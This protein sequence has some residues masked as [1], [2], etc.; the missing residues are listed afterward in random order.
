M[1]NYIA[2]AI[3]TESID[4]FKVD[5]PRLLHAAL[6]IQT[7]ITELMM[8]TDGVNFK[9]E[10]GDILWYVAVFCDRFQV[11]FED[12][13]PLADM[14][15]VE[16]DPFKAA[17][18]FAGE[19]ID[20]MKRM[21]FYGQE[22]SESYLGICVA[23]VVACVEVFAADLNLTMDEIKEA[24]I[25]KLRRR[26]GEKFSEAAA[27]NRDLAAEEEALVSGSQG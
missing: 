21:C 26:F 14:E 16:D 3:K 12:L 11:R 22:M 13:T 4:N 23:S 17:F 27:L 5:E 20:Q 18:Y 6:G 1:Q 19:L 9:E 15:T 2:N 8:A 10:L 25:A 24:N 7:E